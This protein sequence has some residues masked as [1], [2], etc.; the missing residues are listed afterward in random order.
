MRV[1]PLALLLMI[2]AQA[3]AQ[4]GGDVAPRELLL[5]SGS[6]NRPGGDGRFGL[7]FTLGPGFSRAGFSGPTGD[8]GLTGAVAVASARASLH[9]GRWIAVQVGGAGALSIAPRVSSGTPQYLELQGVSGFGLLGGGVALGARDGGLRLSLLGGVAWM[10]ARIDS[11]FG[12]RAGA[13]PGGGCFVELA[14]HWASGGRWTLGLSV[15]AWALAGGD[16]TDW[17]AQ[18]TGWNALGGGLVASAST[19]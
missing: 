6:P 11:S 17:L 16:S 4:A 2:P 12:A 14:H 10:L 5:R 9:L 8:V 19:R 7:T 15:T 13:G 18:P 3:D 1:G